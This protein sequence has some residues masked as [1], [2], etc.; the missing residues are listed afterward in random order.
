MSPS[1]RDM[2]KWQPFP[3]RCENGFGMNVAIIPCCSASVWTMYR[4]KIARSQ[5][6]SASSYVKF[7]SNWPF[8][9]SWSFA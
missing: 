4:K 8:A 7:C 5:E 6:T 3:V 9:S 1:Q 2:W